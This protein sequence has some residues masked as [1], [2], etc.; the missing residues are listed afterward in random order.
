M[1][2]PQTQAETEKIAIVF[3]RAKRYICVPVSVDK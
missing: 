1:Q 2:K 3:K